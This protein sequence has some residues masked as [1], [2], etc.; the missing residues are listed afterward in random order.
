MKR[1]FMGA[2]DDDGTRSA[3]FWIRG[4]L[5]KAQYENPPAI[6]TIRTNTVPALQAQTVQGEVLGGTDG[7]RQQKWT[8]ANTPVIAGSVKV[9]IDDGTGAADW[10]AVSDLLNSGSQ[11]PDLALDA[12]S[13]TLTAGD[14]VH[15]AVPVANPNNPD[16]NVVAVEYRYGGGARGNI[17]EKKINALLTPVDG[18]DGGNVMNLFAA[19]GGRDEEQL[20]DA[21]DRARRMVRSQCRAVTVEDFEAL[22]KQ[23]GDIARAKALP[24][25]HPQFPTVT[26]PGAVSVIIVPN[27]KR[28]PDAPFAPVPSDG[29]MRTVCAYLDIRRLLTSEVFVVAPTY[30]EIVVTAQVVAKD[31]ADTAVVRQAVEQALT[32]YFDPIEG[33]DDKTGWV[34]GQTISYSK[35][36]QEIFTVTGVDSIETLTMA[37]DENEF[38]ECKDVPIHANGLL[39]SGAHQIEVLYA[40]EVVPA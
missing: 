34:F 5:T 11:D 10:S 13:G 23:A 39:S 28:M 12:T 31:D 30:Q 17:A 2:Y 15:G 40:D 16:S 18:I 6:T 29:L 7:T 26:V 24:L 14:G 8:L 9:Q 33:G 20:D 21:K 25:Y 35:V 36:Y 22:A 19:A 32:T 37:L 3:L 4:R 1:D 27:A 38:P